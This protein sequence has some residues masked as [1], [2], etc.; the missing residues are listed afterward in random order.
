MQVVVLVDND[1]Q[2]DGSLD[3]IVAVPAIGIDRSMQLLI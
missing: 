2:H 1:L 3:G